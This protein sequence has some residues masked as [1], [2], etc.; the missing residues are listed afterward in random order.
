MSVVVS[1]RGC[2]SSY[3]HPPRED[4]CSG[5]AKGASVGRGVCLEVHDGVRGGVRCRVMC[6]CVLEEAGQEHA[7][8]SERYGGSRCPEGLSMEDD[9]AQTR[10]GEGE[11]VH[12]LGIEW[13]YQYLGRRVGPPGGKRG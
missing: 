4:A 13:V 2:L 9:A 11:G 6:V 3:R 8:L 12:L 1:R 5:A 7:R 10:L